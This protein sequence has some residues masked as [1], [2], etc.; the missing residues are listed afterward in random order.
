[1]FVRSNLNVFSFGSE[2]LASM[3]FTA[4]FNL[5]SVPAWAGRWSTG[6]WCVNQSFIVSDSR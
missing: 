3:Q 1:M 6:H 4:Q 2:L 5:L